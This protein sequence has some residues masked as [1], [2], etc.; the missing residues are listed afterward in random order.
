LEFTAQRPEVITVDGIVGTAFESALPV[1]RCARSETT[2]DPAEA[3]SQARWS[4]RVVRL[5]MP[6]VVDS[7]TV[8]VVVIGAHFEREHDSAFA[9]Q[10]RR[11]PLAEVS[12]APLP[13]IPGACGVPR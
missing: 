10:H 1:A 13:G 5:V 3:I 9:D 11:N 2:T 6:I 8:P 12:T 7:V 4:K